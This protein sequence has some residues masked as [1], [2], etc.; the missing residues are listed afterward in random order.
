METNEQ[1]WLEF[2]VE[3]ERDSSPG[4]FSGPPHGSIDHNRMYPDAYPPPTAR[5]IH[6][7]VVLFGLLVLESIAVALL[8]RS[9]NEWV[10]PMVCIVAFSFLIAHFYTKVYHLAKSEC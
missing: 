3:A 9:L 4:A 6:P 8:T 5:R 10:L 1:D 7:K 2:I